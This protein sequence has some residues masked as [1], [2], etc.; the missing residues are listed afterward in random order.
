M[1]LKNDSVHIENLC[2]PLKSRL[3]Q[4][5]EAQKRIIHQEV[6]ITSGNDS[7]EHGSNSKHYSNEA[8]DI[9][10][11]NWFCNVSSVTDY[12]DFLYHIFPDKLF[13]LIFEGDHLHIEYDPK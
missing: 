11:N 8:I 3:N 13:D 1:R 12:F 2:E 7:S 6:V 10:I 4:I 5:D 9:R